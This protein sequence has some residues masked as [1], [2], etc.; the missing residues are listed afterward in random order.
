LLT[1]FT[2]PLKTT[3]WRHGVVQSVERL[4]MDWT[5]GVR[6]FDSQQRL[7]IFF[8]TASRPALGLT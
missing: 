5:V 7:G 8:S 3:L 4:A 6:G 2:R 1:V